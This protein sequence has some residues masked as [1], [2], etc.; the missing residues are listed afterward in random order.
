MS[1]AA[2]PIFL[3]MALITYFQQPPLCTVP[4]GYGFLGTMWWMYLV[5]GAVHS[6][7]WFWLVWSWLRGTKSKGRPSPF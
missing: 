4:G 2:T 1:F 7:P 3:L 6:S 5:M